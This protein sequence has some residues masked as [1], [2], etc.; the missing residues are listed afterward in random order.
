VTATPDVLEVVYACSEKFAA[1]STALSYVM[2]TPRFDSSRNIVFL[3][4]R[5]HSSVPALVVKIP[6]IDDLGGFLAREAE[7]L[8]AVHRARPGGF[9]SIPRL[10]A[11]RVQGEELVLVETALTG[12]LMRPSVVRRRP[13]ECV[14]AALRWLVDLQLTTLQRSSWNDNDYQRLVGEP[15]D[16]LERVVAQDEEGS[17]LAAETRRLIAGLREAPLPLVFE[18]GDLSSPNLLLLKDGG[19][20]VV[21]WELSHPKGLPLVDLLFFLAF[22]A[23][24]QRDARTPATSVEAF[25]RAFFGPAA[26]ARRHV[27]RYVEQFPL[28]VSTL[29][30]LFVLCWCRY[31]SNLSVRTAS[32]G[33]AAD[34]SRRLARLRGD[35]YWH[36]WRYAVDHFADLALHP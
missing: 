5:I 3:V 34:A 29:N 33:I 20:G 14:V 16:T 36:L 27:V 18:H 4:Y 12:R 10:I 24:A 19:L 31:L 1:S 21:D 30:A 23:F 11:H 8:R 7:S 17:R 26:W 32:A 13:R 35:R 2:V 6:R 9:D 15:L 28:P 25:R 22:V